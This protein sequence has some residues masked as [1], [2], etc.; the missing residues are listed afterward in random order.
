MSAEIVSNC[1]GV[2]TARIGGVLARPQRA[3]L[4]AAAIEAIREHGKVRMPVLAEDFEGW[5]QGDDWGDV[6]FM[7]NDP[8]IDKLAIVGERH[9]EALAVLFTAKMV[10]RFPI[11]NCQPAEWPRAQAWP[12]ADRARRA[13]GTQRPMRWL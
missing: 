9:W 10:R 1:G 3:A 6:P 2:L 13:R 8:C 4:Q 11:E 5:Q 7:A 12:E